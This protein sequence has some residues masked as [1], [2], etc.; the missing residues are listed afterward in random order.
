MW[1]LLPVNNV[2]VAGAGAANSPLP[3][4]PGV[5]GTSSRLTAKSRSLPSS[6]LLFPGK[7][8]SISRPVPETHTVATPSMMNSHRHPRIPAKPS[9]PAAIPAREQATERA[10]QD[11]GRDEDGEAH[12]LLLGPVPAVEQQQHARRREARLQDADGG[13]QV[14]D[15]P[16][17]RREP[18]GRRQDAPEEHDGGEEDRGP[19]SGTG[20]CWRRHLEDDVS[21]EEDREGRRVHVPAHL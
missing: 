15:G 13:A 7:S 3:P 18:H 11:G 4:P 9:K 6:R 2:I 21:D 5:S 17:C 10:R 14:H 12:R 1:L 20:P 8:S 16:V 19:V